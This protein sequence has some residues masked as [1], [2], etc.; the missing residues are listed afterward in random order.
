MARR[1]VPPPKP[2]S[3]I[4]TAGQK[5]RRIE[6]LQKCITS[7]GAFDYQKMRKRFG[8]PEVVTLEA[9]ID[10]ALSSAF[11][12][13]TPAYMRYNLAAKLDPGPLITNAALRSA[14]LR[15][16]GGP[17]RHDAQAH[18]ARQYFSEGRE[19]SIGLLREAIGTLEDE[20]AAAQPIVEA[21]QKSKG[22]ADA[23]H[24]PPGR[25]VAEATQKAD[26]VRTL[27]PRR[28]GGIDLK[29]VWR[30]VGR[31]WRGRN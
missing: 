13:G 6:R 12:Y 11:G 22:V 9:A 18:E 8:N 1:P 2:R 3:P 27:Q 23:D 7:L 30:R 14:A 15:P 28:R 5:R 19:R 16:V 20:I 24:P 10:K 31:W 17:A 26:E 29:A 21:A 4:L 25:Q